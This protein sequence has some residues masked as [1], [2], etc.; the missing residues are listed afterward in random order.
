MM[1]A[2]ELNR[3]ALQQALFTKQT[4]ELANKN[5]RRNAGSQAIAEF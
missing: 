2:A 4:E 3:Q 1:Q 5:A